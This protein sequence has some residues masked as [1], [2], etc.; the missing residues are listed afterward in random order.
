MLSP[1]SG[2][3]SK[4]QLLRFEGFK[5]L[6]NVKR[7]VSCGLY[8]AKQIQTR[9]KSNVQC[10]SIMGWAGPNTMAKW[11]SSHGNKMACSILEISLKLRI[12]C[13]LPGMGRNWFLCI[14]LNMC[15]YD[16]M[17][18]FGCKAAVDKPPSWTT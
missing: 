5:S 10:N 2:F 6:G 7:K 9:R 1:W 3:S 8:S 18:P 13:D 11:W 4:F 17:I 16:L 14:V 15:Q 12:A